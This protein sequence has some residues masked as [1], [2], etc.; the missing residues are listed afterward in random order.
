MQAYS[1]WVFPLCVPFPPPVCNQ[2]RTLCALIVCLTREGRTEVGPIAHM[3]SSYTLEG[4]QVVFGHAATLQS[5]RRAVRT[6]QLSLLNRLRSIHDDHAFLA[7]I[8]PH[9]PAFPVLANLRCGSWYV[10]PLPVPSPTASTC[11]FKSSDAHCL[12][13]TF[14]PLRLNGHV[15]ALCA[16][17]GGVVIVDST[18]KGKR[19]PDSFSR[20]IPIWCCVVNRALARHRRQRCDGAQSKRVSVTNTDEGDDGWDEELHAP[21]WVSDSE[22]EQILL[23]VDE[24]VHAFMVTRLHPPTPQAISHS[25]PTDADLRSFR[26]RRLRP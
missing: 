12:H 1:A 25:L 2:W 10:P 13:W 5:L 9:Y 16:E 19:F 8:L 26:S 24:W 21:E 23:Q 17:R 15:A 4:R 22:R 11:Y 7:S 6:E 18:R 3:S 20:T 14:S